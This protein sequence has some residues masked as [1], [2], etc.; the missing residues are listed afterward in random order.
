MHL[1]NKTDY[2]QGMYALIQQEFCVFFFCT[3]V[4]RIEHY[5]QLYFKILYFIHS[6][7]YKKSRFIP[8]N[9]QTQ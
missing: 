3:R 8:C 6:A 5:D 1:A 4:E 9:E 7:L 2:V